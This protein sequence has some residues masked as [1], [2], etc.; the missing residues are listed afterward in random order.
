MTKRKRHGRRP[1][2]GRP[3]SRH[4]SPR[5]SRGGTGEPDLMAQVSLA[6]KDP[7]PLELISLTSSLLTVFDPR[8]ADPL[9]SAEEKAQFD[10]ADFVQSLV[11][12]ASA[13]TSALLA[14]IAA[15]TDDSLEKLRIQRELSRRP[16]GT[17]AW[18]RDLTDIVARRV[19]AMPD[20]LGDGE[21]IVLGAPIG[22][23]GFLTAVLYID[24]NSGSVVKDAFVVSD[25]MDAVLESLRLAT[26]IDPDVILTDL[27][28]ADGRARVE[29]AIKFGAITVPRFETDTWPLCRPIVEMLC[30]GLPAGGSGYEH[31][32]WTEAELGALAE[33]FFASP[34]ARG[35]DD[36]DGRGLVDSFL[37]YGTAYGNGDPF[38]WSV[39]RV[40]ILLLDWIPRKIID[41][42]SVLKTVPDLLR[43]YIGFAHAERGIR[44]D[45][46]AEVLDAIDDFAPDYQSII[47]TARPQGPAALIAATNPDIDPAEL[48]DY[49][50]ADALLAEV[51]RERIEA[52]VGGPNTLAALDD[53]ALPDEEFDWLDVPDDIHDVVRDVLLAF[54]SVVD[55]EF[56]IEY[57]TACQRLLHR[58]AVRD[59]T[60]LRR[61]A[62]AETTAAAVC[63]IVGK[64]NRLFGPTLLTKDFL[65][66]FGV[67]T[68]SQRARALLGAAGL[69]N[70]SYDMD[71]GL[72]DLLVADRRRELIELRDRY[73]PPA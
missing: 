1:P 7:D 38:L 28:P 27:D 18:A 22:M 19:V 10:R 49:A 64:A 11:E 31:R 63:W 20:P 42:L 16:F 57:K 58:I 61:K 70:D 9:A 47:R 48:I 41:R 68:V 3:K 55:D 21:S 54:D 73:A 53:L 13:E 17:P 62:R 33:R 39:Q 26:A 37:W 30:R 60:P 72:P 50:G 14:T 71:L 45:V 66:R 12:I 6:M 36:E 29:H 59:A 67:T 23:A 32:E 2:K 34:F 52:A 56:D 65:A 24:H 5:A 8:S 51:V 35:L 43:T 44:D 46:T 40:E 15:M 25:E 69:E 4:R